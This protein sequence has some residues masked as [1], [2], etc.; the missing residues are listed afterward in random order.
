VAELV[1][2]ANGE[3]QP[4]T[5]KI[6]DAKRLASL[7]AETAHYRGEIACFSGQTVS[8]DS[9]RTRTVIYDGE[10]VVA[11]NAVAVNADVQQVTSGVMLE[12]TP[13]IVGDTQTAVVQV[14]SAYAEWG[15]P[16]KMEMTYSSTQPGGS[17]VQ[18][19][20]SYDRL[21]VLRQE[22]RTAARIPLNQPVLVGG[23]T[24]EPNAGDP[25][26]QPAIPDFT[27]HGGS[28]RSVQNRRGR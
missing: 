3:K 7:G 16:D 27:G 8:I 18:G 14:R 2:R 1:T 20:T 10:P 13:L 26:G 17:N 24:L 21:N 23:M 9:G 6:V 4:Q 11:Q 5:P 19:P 15:K 22:L 25:S 28:L 12:V